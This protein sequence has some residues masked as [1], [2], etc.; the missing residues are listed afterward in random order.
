MLAASCSSAGGGD[1][2]GKS[3]QGQQ[4]EVAATWSGTDQERFSAVLATFEER[5][6]AKVKF[7]STG[8]DMAE[9]LDA[10]LDRGRVPDVALLPQVGLLGDLA[11]RGALKPLPRAAADLVARNYDPVWRELGTANGQLFGVW[12]RAVNK[13]TLWFNRAVLDRAGTQPPVNWDELKAAAA[14]LTR[15]GVPPFSVGAADAW[16]L[17]DW[18]ENVYLRTAGSEAYIDLARH[19]L[20]WDDPT[21]V[22]ALG[23]L[24]EVFRPEWLAGG[25]QGARQTRFQ[26]AVTGVFADPPQAAFVLEADVMA[27]QTGAPPGDA[28]L[29]DFPSIGGSPPSVVVGG[30]AAVL[31]ADTPGGRAL[32]EFLARPE[33]AEKWAALGGFTSPNKQV[34]ASAY[35]TDGERRAAKGLVSARVVRFDMSDL[36]PAAFGA[37]PDRGLLPLFQEYLANPASAP[38]VA[39]RIE[40][41]AVDTFEP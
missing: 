19:H 39:R 15:A 1:A 41:V 3:L 17:T 35:R 26:D 38:D 30:D 8:G 16:T 24:T 12:F 11:S 10:R 37:D 32:V 13:S 29:V 21:V 5:T 27:G 7:T 40:R 22:E 20:A 23:R 6:G 14:A 9:A 33:A 28:G 36:Q 18:F 2:G 31:L 25:P 4:V 34:D